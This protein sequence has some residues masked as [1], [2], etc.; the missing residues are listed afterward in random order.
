MQKSRNR[1]LP[2]LLLIGSAL[3]AQNLQQTIEKVWQHIGGIQTYEKARYLE[4]TFQVEREGKVL[5]T[6][7]HLWDRYTGNHVLDVT[8]P[9]TGDQVRVYSNINT[10]KGVTYKNSKQL[11]GVDNTDWVNQA[12]GLF[13]NDS[14]WLLMPAKLEDPGV[15]VKID[16]DL[17]QSSGKTVLDLTFE[18]V[19]NT[20]GDHYWVF[21][22]GDGSIARW[23]FKLQGGREGD[24]NWLDE[25]DVGMGVKLST[26]KVSADGKVT[27]SFPQV[28]FTSLQDIV[29]FEPPQIVK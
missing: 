8:E 13:V 18:N 20:P 29:R 11:K 22:N 16:K 12:Y 6:R 3:V 2:V 21:V 26:R 19:G 28:E 4:F 17:S 23:K 10:R 5:A 15:K 1:L 9:K 25:K 7:H 14:Y 24:F 27:I